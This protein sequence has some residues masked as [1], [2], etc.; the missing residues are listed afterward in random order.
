MSE[1][2]TKDPSMYG[3]A[4]YERSKLDF[5]PSPPDTVK[6]L[7]NADVLDPFSLVWE[8]AAGDGA[9]IRELEANGFPCVGT[10]IEDYEYFSVSPGVDFLKTRVKGEE[11]KFCLGAKF[12][13][14]D[15]PCLKKK[16][17]AINKTDRLSV[18]SNPPYN[19]PYKGIN[20]DFVQKSIDVTEPTEGIVAML[21]RHDW[22]TSKQSKKFTEHPAYAGRVTLR[23]RPRW[24]VGSTGSPRH[25]YAWFLW[26]WRTVG[27]PGITRYADRPK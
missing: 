22:D 20:L 6:A 12:D 18:V 25:N 17:D 21:L 3:K 4:K 16:L 10:D 27:Q 23:Y 2:A 26:D 13:R 8:P 1:P 7:I 14:N 5:Y 24:I 9:I 19:V 11:I 15:W